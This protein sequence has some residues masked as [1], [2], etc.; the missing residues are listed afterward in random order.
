MRFVFNSIG[1]L[2]PVMAW[3]VALA[4]GIP[5]GAAVV[6]ALVVVVVLCTVSIK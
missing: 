5:A 3:E 4:V 6:V 1:S 2:P